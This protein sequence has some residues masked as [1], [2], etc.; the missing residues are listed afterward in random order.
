MVQSKV[1]HTKSGHCLYVCTLY[2]QSFHT[3]EIKKLIVVFSLAEL[4][5]V[6]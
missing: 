3:S 5:V 1:I 6:R 2:V 4:Y